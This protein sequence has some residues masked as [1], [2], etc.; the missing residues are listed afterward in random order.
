MD[1][2]GLLSPGTERQG[3]Q[4]SHRTMSYFAFRKTATAGA[5][6]FDPLGR[7]LTAIPLQSY[8]YTPPEHLSFPPKSF[9]IMFAV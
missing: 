6:L 3:F 9:H 1:C 8:D 2:P 7:M 5:N 4:I